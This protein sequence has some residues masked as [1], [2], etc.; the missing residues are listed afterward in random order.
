M[1]YHKPQAFYAFGVAIGAFAGANGGLVAPVVLL[2][3]TALAWA[4]DAKFWKS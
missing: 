2:L 4:A 3:A 1:E